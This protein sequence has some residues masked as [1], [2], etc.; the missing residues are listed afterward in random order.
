MSN[1]Y[2]TIG[3]TL[4]AHGKLSDS[5][6]DYV[7]LDPHSLRSSSYRSSRVLR[8]SSERLEE[9]LLIHRGLYVDEYGILTMAYK[10]SLVA[11][12]V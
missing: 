2:L 10:G 4:W 12:L 11:D 6:C 8:V 7:S 9:R 5:N 1:T 3:L